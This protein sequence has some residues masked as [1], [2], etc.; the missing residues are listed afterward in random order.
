MSTRSQRVPLTLFFA[1]LAATLALAARQAKAQ[2]TILWDF[3]SGELAP[4]K[5]VEGENSKPIGSRDVEFHNNSTP[6]Q[7]S[8]KFYLTTLE[9]SRDDAPTDD[10][11]CVI[12]SPVFRIEGDAIRFLVGGA[13][14]RDDVRVELAQLVKGKDILQAFQR[15][16][17]P[18]FDKLLKRLP[19]DASGRAVWQRE[20]RILRL[21]LLKSAELMV[22]VVVRHLRRVFDIIQKTCVFELLCE[23][24]DFFLWF[25]VRYPR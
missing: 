23:L 14:K 22:I 16:F 3:E 11:R 20:R 12:E 19:A 9:S 7:K 24:F 1:F 17:V 10:V 4:W 25:H 13:G 6:Y 15:H 8:G 18:D 5:I 2:D 21:K